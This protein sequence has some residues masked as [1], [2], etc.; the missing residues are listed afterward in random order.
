MAPHRPDEVDSADGQDR[1]TF[2][3]TLGL[4]GGALAGASA[5]SAAPVQL[6]R[7]RSTGTVTPATGGLQRATAR[8]SLKQPLTLQKTTLAAA[9]LT[10]PPS[11]NIPTMGRMPLPSTR[12]RALQTVFETRSGGGGGLVPKD[13]GL[14]SMQDGTYSLPADIT[15]GYDVPLA[16][17]YAEGITLTPSGCEFAPGAEYEGTPPMK[18]MAYRTTY[19]SPDVFG[20]QV[21]LTTDATD[22]TWFFQIKWT[23]PW[24]LSTRRT[25]VL[26]LSMEH[27][28]SD[29]WITLA[30]AG[31]DQVPGQYLDGIS[32][33]PTTDNTQMALVEMPGSG[34]I[35]YTHTLW[36][37]PG[38]YG[39]KLACFN[40]LNIIAV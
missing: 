2:L 8:M 17:A 35:P 19:V 37:R 4:A 22:Y 26:E 5:A 38:N 16:R 23:T 21:W 32:F 27:F 29:F 3:K 6:P 33:V 36:F 9:G 1:R 39:Q 7:T 11:P 40:W 34:G 14:R 15:V 10:P 13:F 24:P 12:Q 31:S 25:Y 28:D 20:K 30:S 18:Y